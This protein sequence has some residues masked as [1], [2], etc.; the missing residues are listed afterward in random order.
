MDLE[1]VS[2]I[3]VKVSRELE[4]VG[5]VRFAVLPRETK[6]MYIKRKVTIKLKSKVNGEDGT[7]SLDT[8]SSARCHYQDAA[9]GLNKLAPEFAPW[10]CVG[11]NTE[12]I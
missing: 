7:W 9:G 8:F 2:I 4:T 6:I 3:N 11:H 10:V 1:T 5:G 12:S